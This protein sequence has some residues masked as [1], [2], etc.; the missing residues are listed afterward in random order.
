[1]R[2][3]ARVDGLAGQL[4]EGIATLYSEYDAGAGLITRIVFLSADIVQM[5]K[6]DRQAEACSLAGSASSSTL[7]LRPD[8]SHV[9]FVQAGQTD[10][11]ACPN[12][13]IS[14]SSCA[15][16]SLGT[17]P[18]ATFAVCTCVRIVSTIS[19]F[20][21][22]VISPG[23]MKLDMPATTLRMI[24]PERVLGMSGTIHTFFGRAIFPMM[25]STAPRTRSSISSVG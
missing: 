9:G 24:F 8:A 16:S 25:V 15:D 17:S 3:C 10:Y 1:M 4:G 20:A 6:S 12:L 21:R 13:P 14:S 5:N 18:R 22:V 11:S 2:C 23:L 19:G 7:T